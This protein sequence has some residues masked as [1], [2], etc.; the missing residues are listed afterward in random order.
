[1]KSDYVFDWADL[2][3]SSKKS[4]RDLKKY[5]HSGNI[6]LGISKDKFVN[7]FEGQPQFQMLRLEGAIKTII[8]RA[9]KSKRKFNIYTLEYFQRELPYI[10]EK[11]KFN[12]VILVNGSWQHVFHTS[13]TYYVLTTKKISYEM[14]SPFI[15]EEEA[16]NYEVVT[17]KKINNI[18]DDPNLYRG[19]NSVYSEPE[20]MQIANSTAKRS[21]DY[22]YQTGLVLAK[23]LPAT[24]QYNAIVAT[25]NQ[26]VPFQTYA[27]LY[28][29]SREK[30]FSAPHDLNHYD[31]VHAEV[32]LLVKYIKYLESTDENK[33]KV[34]SLVGTSL[35]I[36]LMPCP[37]CARMLSQTDIEEFIYSV[38]HSDGY[39][40]KLLEAAGKK[41]R[42]LV[43]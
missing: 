42:R 5:L 13:P 7:G 39:A 19:H 40:L 14:I 33:R 12:R 23:Q 17:D 29:A 38:D 20:L 41:V 1:M 28:G 24:A 3:F 2:A 36:N 9:H 37:A 27:M 8:D 32:S 31:T 25:F 35:F 18:L 11:I 10:V 6:I 21:Y 26:V 30:Y 22:S 16:R 15:D 34:H 43:I 4:V